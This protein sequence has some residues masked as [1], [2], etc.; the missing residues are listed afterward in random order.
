MAKRTRLPIIL[1]DTSALRDLT[2][3]EVVGDQLPLNRGGTA[4]SAADT[5]DA[6]CVKGGR[7]LMMPGSV[8]TEMFPTQTGRLTLNKDESGQ[9]VFPL[10]AHHT[11]FEGADKNALYQYFSK[12]A[13]EGKL[14]CYASA[15]DMLAAGEVTN[16]KGGI[17]FVHMGEPLAPNGQSYSPKKAQRLIAT[18]VYSRR[19]P[20][21]NSFI[22]NALPYSS[23]ESNPSHSVHAGPNLFKDAGD[24]DIYELASTIDRYSQQ[25]GDKVNFMVL[26]TDIGLARRFN[27]ATGE[28]VTF[29]KPLNLVHSMVQTGLLANG[30]E[31]AVENA[32]IALSE[33]DNVWAYPVIDMFTEHGQRANEQRTQNIADWINETRNNPDSK[34]KAR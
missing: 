22:P 18:P 31:R 32:V 13:Q 6:L 21:H 30:T 11:M 2:D 7:T 33:K 26:N 29:A 3:I 34:N 16:P 25:F 27:N 8:L 9:F 1:A 15:H 5:I 10:G 4:F 28:S 23:I 19:A 24:K 14:R 20:Q 17:V 12:L